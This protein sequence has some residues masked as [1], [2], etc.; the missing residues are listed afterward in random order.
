MSILSNMQ[1]SI[2]NPRSPAIDPGQNASEPFWPPEWGQNPQDMEQLVQM[3]TNISDDSSGTEQAQATAYFFDAI[4]RVEHTSSLR[5]TEHPVQT[6]ANISDHAYI[7][8]AHVVMEIG[9][10]DVMDT[11]ITG[12]FS[13]N[14]SKSVSAYQTLKRLQARRMPLTVT[15]RLNVYKNMLIEQLTSPDDAKTLYGLRATVIMKEIITVDVSNVTV[16]A[17]PQ[18]TGNTPK[19]PIQAAQPKPEEKSTIIRKFEK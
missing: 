1:I 7:M 12:Q 6:G 14:K 4:I 19:G 3:R 16:S 18:T 8:P 10:S 11:L 2:M 17:R 9:M 15:T 5:I 13:D